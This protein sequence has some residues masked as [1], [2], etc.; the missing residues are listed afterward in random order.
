MISKINLKQKE[1]FNTRGF[2]C[3]ENLIPIELVHQLRDKFES[4]FAGKFETGVYPD[5]W[6]WREGMSLPDVTRHMSNLWKSDLTIASVAL[7]AVIG[8][9]SAV[10]TRRSIGIHRHNSSTKFTDRKA[11]IYGRYKRV[12]SYDMDESY[13]PILWR[14]DGYRAPFLKDYCNDALITHNK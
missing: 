9:I 5:E 2:L 8:K 12:D 11:Y 13:F 7:S 1:E 6:Y 14:K 4:F 10:R 3:I